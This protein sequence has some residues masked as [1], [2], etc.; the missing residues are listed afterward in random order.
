MLT[1][2][3]G[4][5]RTGKSDTVLRRMAEQGDTGRQ[6]LLVPEHASHAAEVDL[7]AACG[8]TVSRH[9][10]VLSFHRLTTRVLSR[11]GGLAEVTLDAGGKLLILQRALCEIAPELKIYRRPSRRAAFLEQMLALFDELHSYHITP[12]QLAELI[13]T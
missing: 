2:L 3:M 1:V 11:T 10:E 5:A 6:I 7:C 4:R 12:E 8:P 13:L 9:A